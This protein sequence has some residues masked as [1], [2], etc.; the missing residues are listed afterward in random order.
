MIEK[1]KSNPFIKTPEVSKD[2]S[3]AYHLYTLI[4]DF[5]G[6]KKSRNK[7]MHELRKLNIGSQVLYIPVN[8]QTYYLKKKN[9]I[10]KNFPNTL[11]YYGSCLSIPIFADM[12]SKDAMF[13]ADQINRLIKKDD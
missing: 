4:I 13:I 11:K 2:V 9:F 8:L 1:F 10:E 7:I 6:I 3:H 12:K 5:I